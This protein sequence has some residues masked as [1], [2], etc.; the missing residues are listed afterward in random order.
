MTPYIAR[1][2]DTGMN[3]NSIPDDRKKAIGGTS[4]G[5]WKP[6]TGQLNFGGLQANAARC[7]RV[8]KIN[9]GNEWVVI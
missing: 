7:S 8:P 4:I 9:L 3:N 1:L 6:Q 5:S 2:L